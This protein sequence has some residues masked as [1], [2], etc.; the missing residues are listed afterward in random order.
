MPVEHPVMNQTGDVVRRSSWDGGAGPGAG[1]FNDPTKPSGAGVG[2][3]WPMR[4]ARLAK[5]DFPHFRLSESLS[6]APRRYPHAQ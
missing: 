6:K 3:R 5:L 2:T 1:S 4:P